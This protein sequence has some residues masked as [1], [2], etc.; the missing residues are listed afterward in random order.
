MS[1]TNKK[2][3]TQSVKLTLAL[4]SIAGGR[5]YDPVCG[6]PAFT[7]REEPYCC[8]ELLIGYIDILINYTLIKIVA[9]E[10]F[11]SQRFLETVLKVLVLEESVIMI[12][13]FWYKYGGEGLVCL[14]LTLSPV[15]P[16]WPSTLAVWWSLRTP[17]GLAALMNITRGQNFALRRCFNALI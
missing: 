4:L 8:H 14:E 17:S 16:P 10:F 1:R 12:I 7:T 6:N 13:F 2:S 3:V 9:I 5:L 15:K 11:N